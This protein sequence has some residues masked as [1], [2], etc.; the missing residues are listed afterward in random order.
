MGI[1]ARAHYDPAAAVTKST[2]ALLAMTAMDITNLRVT[3]T[4]TKTAVFVRLCGVLHGAATL[5]QILLGVMRGATIKGRG[6]PMIGGGNLAATSL[7][8]AEAAFTVAVDAGVAETWDAA[9]AVETLVAGT[10]IK[11]GGPNDVT[12]NNAFGGFS[13]EVYE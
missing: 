1:L 9:W 8:M 3:F 2:A 4:P 12:A 5:P 10:G 13:F 6:I 11:Y 7:I